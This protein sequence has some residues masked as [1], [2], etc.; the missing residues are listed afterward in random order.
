MFYMY[1]FH[2]TLFSSET[3]TQRKTGYPRRCEGG[4]GREGRGTRGGARGGREEEEEEE[5]FKGI[6]KLQEEEG[7]N[8]AIE[9]PMAP[10]ELGRRRKISSKQLVVGPPHS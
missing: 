7:S 10:E 3:T 5:L 2:Y 4:A 8:D 9:G 6:S 1:I